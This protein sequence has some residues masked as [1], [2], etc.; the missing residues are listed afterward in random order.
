MTSGY[1]RLFLALAAVM[2][3]AAP[4]AS[5]PQAPSSPRLYVFDCGRLDIADITPYQLK[6]EEMATNVMSVPCCLVA[7]PKG[8][9]MWDVGAVPDGAIPAGGTGRL[10]IY[11]TSTKKLET[12]LS[13]IGYTPADINYLAI[14][15][16]HWD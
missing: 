6:K 15:H 9:L 16:F 3:A 14:S 2:L 11:G 7:H 5:A 1:S 10:R 13:E 12:Q 8:T 4:A